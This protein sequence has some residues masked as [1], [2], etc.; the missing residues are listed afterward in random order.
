[1]TWTTAADLRAVWQR[2]WAR[3]D[4]PRAVVAQVAAQ[5]LPAHSFATQAA[6]ADPAAEPPADPP[7]L[8]FPCRMPLRGPDAR[9]IAEH[10]QAVRDWIATLQAAP[11]LRLTWR[12]VRHRVHGAQRLPEAA[13]V[14]ALDDALA[15]A[16]QRA[17]ATRLVG[18]VQ[19][20]ANALPGLLPWLAQRP[21]QALALADDWPRLLAV[22]AWMAEHP[23]PGIHLR[24]VDVPGVHTK[25]IEAHRGLL[26]AWLERLLPPEAIDAAHTGV[27]GFAARHGF[28]DK[29]PRVRLRLL[30][31][32]TGAPWWDVAQHDPA[33]P[34]QLTTQRRAAGNCLDPLGGR[35]GHRP[36]LEAFSASPPDLTLD[37]PSLARLHLPAQRLIVIE[38]EITFLAL[39]PLPG[40][41]LVAVFGAGYAAEVADALAAAR[42]VEGVPMHYWG[43]IDTHGFAILDRW[44]ARF[45]RLRS[46]L[47][48][49]ETL[50]AHRALWGEEPQPASHPLV[51]LNGVERALYDDL[52]DDRLAPRLRL[53]QERIGFGWVM[54]A[55]QGL[56]APR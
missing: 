10:F 45:P 35:A 44:R 47:M 4:L 9:A 29:P 33:D 49:R 6:P 38:N 46:L 14:D 40:S 43:D 52:R 5:S 30:D 15:L 18:L 12:E 25:F 56:L 28:L 21:L 17:E 37:G 34:A 23:R 50:L 32:T 26:S 3:G 1:V 48:D 41:G 11:R 51:L 39:P 36:A 8:A 7:T 54:R 19:Q 13:W 42:W 2:R 27:A 31:P 24:Q 53:E 55:L 22:A 16:G 20:T